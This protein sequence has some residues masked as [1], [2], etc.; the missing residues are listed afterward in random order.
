MAGIYIHIPFCAS[1]CSYCDFYSTLQLHE[2]GAP[3]VEA[4]LAEAGLRCG[5]LRGESVVTLYMGGGTPSQL[6]LPLLSRLK[7]SFPDSCSV[8]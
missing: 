5:E 7:S 2:A 1:R 8:S 3:Y 6:P 4:L